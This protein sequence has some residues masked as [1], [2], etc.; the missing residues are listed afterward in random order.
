LT[1]PPFGE[2]FAKAPKGDY[3]NRKNDDVI[4]DPDLTILMKIPKPTK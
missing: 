4:T 1:L 2:A 3:C